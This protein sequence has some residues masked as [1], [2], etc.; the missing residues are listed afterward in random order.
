MKPPS[1]RGRYETPYTAVLLVDGAYYLIVER[2]RDGFV[3]RRLSKAEAAVVQ[4]A[5]DDVHAD[6]EARLRA[7]SGRF[8]PVAS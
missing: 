6:L 8:P 4:R 7:P 1:R 2:R 5:F 3:T